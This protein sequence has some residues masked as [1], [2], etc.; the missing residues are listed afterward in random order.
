MSGS[1]CEPKNF[2]LDSELERANVK[3]SELVYNETFWK[4]LSAS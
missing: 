3:E 1:E 4:F 2:E